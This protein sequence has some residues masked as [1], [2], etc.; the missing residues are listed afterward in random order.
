[1]VQSDLIKGETAIELVSPPKSSSRKS[2]NTG[3]NFTGVKDLSYF[4]NSISKV[5]GISAYQ[6]SE[7]SPVEKTTENIRTYA[8][9]VNCI[10]N[11]K[12]YDIVE[13]SRFD[14]VDCYVSM[15][16]CVNF[17]YV[18][19]SLQLQILLGKIPSTAV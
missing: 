17:I 8:K 9:A 6:N 13:S 12:V 18:S 7:F 2:H 19:I 16:E 5:F 11:C 1:M 15:L 4:K 3:P 10:S 14:T